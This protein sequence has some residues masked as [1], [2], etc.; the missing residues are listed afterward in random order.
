MTSDAEA[1]APPDA[2]FPPLAPLA[3][4]APFAPF[5]AASIIEFAT[6]PLNTRV[7]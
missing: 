1:G 4:L 3:P 7:E 6:T 5:V 2:L